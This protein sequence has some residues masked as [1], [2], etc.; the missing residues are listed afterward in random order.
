MLRTALQV[1]YWWRDEA[2]TVIP[3]NHDRFILYEQIPKE[4]MEAWFD[5]VSPHEPRLKTFEEGIALLEV[6][7]NRDP[8]EDRHPTESWLPNTIGRIYEEVPDFVASHQAELEGMRVVALVH[9]HITADWYPTGAGALS[10]L[11]E[12]ADGVE[13]FVESLDLVDESA[14]ILHGHKHDIMPVE[15]HHGEHPVGCPGGFHESLR[16]NIIDFDQ[17]DEQVIT[18]IELRN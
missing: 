14:V 11:M 3:G 5:V 17:H 16:L 6:E 13:P 8:D 9:H 2:L 4:P 15:Y 7:T 18:Q 10:G 1:T 12:P